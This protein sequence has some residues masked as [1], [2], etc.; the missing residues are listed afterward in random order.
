MRLARVPAL[1][2]FVVMRIIHPRTG[3][4]EGATLVRGP[5]TREPLRPPQKRSTLGR[6][7]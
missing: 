4:E 2:P 7:D 6:A 1:V 3:P 5:T